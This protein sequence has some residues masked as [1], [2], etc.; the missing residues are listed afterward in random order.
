MLGD[1][2]GFAQASSQENCAIAVR[3]AQHDDTGMGKLSLYGDQRVCAIRA[4]QTEIHQ[5]DVGAMAPEF[6][7]SL[8]GIASYG[9]NI[10]MR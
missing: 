5:G 4:G 7:N 8:L 10:Q 1:T 6:C 2:G 3:G 9:Q